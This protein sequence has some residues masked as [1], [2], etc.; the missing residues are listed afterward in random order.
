ML[1]GMSAFAVY[2]SDIVYLFGKVPVDAFHAAQVL[3]RGVAHAVRGCPAEGGQQLAAPGG[4]DAGDVF[5]AGGVRVLARRARWPV[6]AKRWASSRISWIRVRARR[7]RRGAGARARGRRGR[8]ALRGPACRLS[9]LATPNMAMDSSPSFGEHSFA[10]PIWPLPPSIRIT[11]G[12]HP[13]ARRLPS[14]SAG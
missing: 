14:R 6:M 9:P 10:T 13:L 7:G 11:S 3:D 1:R 4:A 2:R 12:A 5:E 8:P